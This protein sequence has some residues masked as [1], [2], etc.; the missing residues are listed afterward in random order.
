MSGNYLYANMCCFCRDVLEI[1]CNVPLENDYR[2]RCR[3]HHV[4]K[5]RCRTQKKNSVKETI[6]VPVSK[7][8][9]HFTISVR[10]RCSN[11]SPYAP[12]VVHSHLQVFPGNNFADFSSRFS[13]ILQSR[14]A[15]RPSLVKASTGI[16][17][18]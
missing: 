4:N 6:F 13:R 10:L 12:F 1:T 11:L 8:V 15:P 7:Y 9:G 3:E 17:S 16:S 18:P 2:S 5:P 14:A